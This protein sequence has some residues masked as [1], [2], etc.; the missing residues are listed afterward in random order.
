MSTGP[1]DVRIAEA[2]ARWVVGVRWEDVPEPVRRSTVESVFQS[3]AGGVAGL[4]MPEMQVALAWARAA[5]ESGPATIL[6]DGLRVPLATAVPTLY[7]P[8]VMRNVPLLVTG[9]PVWAATV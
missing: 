5:G 9:V 4:D 3:V 2:V 8:W 7:V 1:A 6:G